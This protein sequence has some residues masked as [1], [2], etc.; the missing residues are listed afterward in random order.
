MP[1]RALKNSR[2]LARHPEV[3]TFTIKNMQNINIYH[4]EYANHQHLPSTIHK[5][6]TLTINNTQN[7]N[8]YHKEYAKHQHLPSKIHKTLTLTI[9]NTQNIN[10]YHQQNEN[11]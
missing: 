1:P 7:I 3:S 2:H 4:K 6:L 5:T 11:L 8:I 9:N 10:T